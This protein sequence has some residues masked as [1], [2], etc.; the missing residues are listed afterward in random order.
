M[1]SSRDEV[2]TRARRPPDLNS[3]SICTRTSFD[4]LPWCTPILAAEESR[5]LVRGAD[6]GGEPDALELAAGQVPQPLEADRELRAPLVG[7]E[8]VDLVDDDPADGSE[9]LP[10]LA[11][12]EEDLE[13]LR[14]RD[15]DIRR[16]PRDR[17]ALLRRRVPMADR[18]ADAESVR[19][20]RHPAEHVPVQGAEGRDVEAR[21]RL[22]LFPQ[23][24]VEDREQSGFRLPDPGRGDEEDILA[25]ENTRDRAPL[26]LGEGLNTEG[27][28]GIDDPRVQAK[29]LHARRFNGRWD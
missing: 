2:H 14:R 22:G 8:L 1:P 24:P 13:R 16:M 3:S 12:G 26:R 17:R 20:E 6:R 9:V 15:E 28:D 4:R 19:E 27:P 18:D 10:Q 25:R 21:G 11:T 23:E 5:D 7:G 29:A